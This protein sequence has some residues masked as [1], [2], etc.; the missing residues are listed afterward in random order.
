MVK[1]MTKKVVVSQVQ[2]T[3]E[4]IRGLLLQYFYDRNDKATSVRGKR[5]GSSVRIGDMKKE[6]KATQGLTQQEILRNLTYLISQGWVEEDS[7]QKAYRTPKG[8]IQ[9]SET[10]Y[11]KIT[12]AGIDKIEG[13]GE[14]TMKNE[15]AVKIEAIGQNLITVGDGNRINV[16]FGD[17]GN[18]LSELKNEIAS[19][20]ATENE[21]TDCIADV[22]TIQSQLAKP[23]PN[24]GVIE[25]LWNVLKGTA[26]V[27]GCTTLAEKISLYIKNMQ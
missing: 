11:Y 24:K 18:A 23:N 20:S 13:E 8:T 1:K 12:A 3:N 27:S 2:R 7:V 4:D 5:K 19:S 15:P 9:P 26:V 22:N 16:S 10:K 21:K 14:Y 6:L 17:L 25:T